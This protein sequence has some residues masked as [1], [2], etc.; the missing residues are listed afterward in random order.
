MEPAPEAPDDPAAEGLAAAEA[1]ARARAAARAKGL[2]PGLKPRRRPKDVPGGR[3]RRGGRDPQLLSDQI[4]RFVSER[5]WG[6]D[7]AVGSVIGRW[8]AIVGP[9]IAAHCIPTDFV[10]GVLTVRAD[11][12][13]WATQLR[14]LESTLMTRLAEEVGEGTV[15]ELRVIGPSAPPWSRGRHR[16]QGGRGPRDTYG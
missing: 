11:S 2:R 10:D 7:V 12:T 5:G 16:V 3:D 13:A 6:A 15:T 4:E 9:E 14:L 1:L 8:P